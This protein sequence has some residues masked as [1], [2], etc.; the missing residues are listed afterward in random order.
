MSVKKK[1]NKTFTKVT[2]GMGFNAL[3]RHKLK[4]TAKK[5]TYDVAVESVSELVVMGTCYVAK[6]ALDVVTAGV[7]LAKEKLTNISVNVEVSAEIPSGDEG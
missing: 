5:F 6:S 4:K 3:E 7:N 1:V 2:K